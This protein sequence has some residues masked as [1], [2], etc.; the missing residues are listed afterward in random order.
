MN[1]T[2]CPDGAALPAVRAVAAGAATATSCGA[3]GAATATSFP[4]A[5]DPPWA[6]CLGCS[7]LG[8]GLAADAATCLV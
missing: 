7:L 5:V 3:A 2:S 1:G 8:A 4:G 6:G